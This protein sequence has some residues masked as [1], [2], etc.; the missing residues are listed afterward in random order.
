MPLMVKWCSKVPRQA[1]AVEISMGGTLRNGSPNSDVT[2]AS[3]NQATVWNP[4]S[5]LNLVMS[6]KATGIM[7]YSIP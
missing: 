3:I 5:L 6:G 7:V 2:V 1:I 4:Q